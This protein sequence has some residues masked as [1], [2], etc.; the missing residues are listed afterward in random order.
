MYTSEKRSSDHYDVRRIPGND[1]PFIYPELVGHISRAGDCWV[2]ES[3]A[4]VVGYFKK[5]H[6]AFGAIKMFDSTGEKPP[7]DAGPA[8]F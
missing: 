3:G 1:T 5:R 4:E 8:E 6:H 7:S 2:A